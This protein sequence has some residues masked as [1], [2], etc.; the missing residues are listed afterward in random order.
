[1]EPVT[2]TTIGLLLLLLLLLE[3]EIDASHPASRDEYND[4]ND[5]TLYRPTHGGSDV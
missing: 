1:M 3:W 5:A 4:D 2:T